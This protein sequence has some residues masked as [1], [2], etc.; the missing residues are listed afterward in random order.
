MLSIFAVCLFLVDTLSANQE[1]NVPQYT[2]EMVAA[3][4]SPQNSI[5]IRKSSTG[6]SNDNH[7]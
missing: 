3:A 7:R 5:I 6:H 2:N 1:G 4:F